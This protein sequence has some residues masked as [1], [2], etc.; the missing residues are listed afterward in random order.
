[1][2]HL[3]VSNRFSPGFISSRPLG[4]SKTRTGKIVTNFTATLCALR[5]CCLLILRKMLPGERRCRKL[6]VGWSEAYVGRFVFDTT[7]DGK[8]M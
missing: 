8:T 1:M 6:T 5:H 4:S 7:T 3:K 2:S